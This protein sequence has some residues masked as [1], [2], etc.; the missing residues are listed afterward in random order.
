MTESYTTTPTEKAIVSYQHAHEPVAPLTYYRATN[1]DDMK[2]LAE[3]MVRSGFFSD[4]ANANQ[5]LMK[6]VAGAELGI[7]P[8]QS[9]RSVYFSKQGTPSF[10]SNF[11]ATSIRKHPDY[12][13]EIK[14]LTNTECTIAF[15]R[16]DPK[17]EKGWIESTPSI[18]YTMEEAI[19]AGIARKDVWQKYPK[20]LLFA[21][22]LT[23]GARQHCP[24]VL[25]PLPAYTPEEIEIDNAV[26]YS[27][28]D[29]NGESVIVNAQEVAAVEV[30]DEEPVV[31]AAEQNSGI[32]ETMEQEFGAVVVEE[33]AAEEV[34]Q[35]AAAVADPAPTA[36]VQEEADPNAPPWHDPKLSLNDMRDVLYAWAIDELGYDD[37]QSVR[38]KLISA[39]RWE[40][41]LE[42]VKVA[43]EIAEYL[44]KQIKK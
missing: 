7:G 10:S 3:T 17:T 14:K 8:I 11:I 41:G 25:G 22:A 43:D 28:P 23:R 6:I 35:P 13:Y 42:S 32:V 26:V 19:A 5:A 44:K 2:F 1:M 12:D 34:E 36:E 30:V 16:R 21:R 39:G 27:A 29:K 33:S 31:E 15:Y 18:T 37:I 20:D 9:L 38:N 4:I 40:R 24:D